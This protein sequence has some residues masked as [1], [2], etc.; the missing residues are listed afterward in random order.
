M[1]AP[2]GNFAR[3]S[4]C[5]SRDATRVNVA[6]LIKVRQPGAKA[7]HVLAEDISCTGCRVQ[8]PHNVNVGDRVWVTF[9]GLRAIGARI[10]WTEDFRLG[11]QFEVPLHAAVFQALV[12]QRTGLHKYM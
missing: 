9:P 1:T 10:V 7:I 12:P 6:A 4:H 5:E 8:W 2:K 11:C 3:A